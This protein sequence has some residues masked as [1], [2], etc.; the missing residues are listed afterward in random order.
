VR[1]QG[2][3]T[4]LA[5][6]YELDAELGRSGTGVVWRARD[7]IL[8]RIVVVKVL[9][10][11]L[12][13]DPAFDA[14]LAED[15]RAAAGVSAPG[16]T[17]LL[18]TAREDGISYLVREH[19]AGTSLRA[20]LEMGGPLD[21]HEAVR[22][23]L[24]VVE[25]LAA[26]HRARVLHLDLKPTNVV[27]DA[28][29]GAVRL[30]DLGIGSAV[31]ATRDPHEAMRILAPPT[32]APEQRAGDPVDA[33][34][35]V[36]LAGVLLFEA[37]AGE[38][39][40]GRRSVRD[41][42][43]DVPRELDAVVRRALAPDPDQRPASA[44][45]L[46]AALRP[47]AI[48][49]VPTDE[50]RRSWFRTWL[51]LPLLLVLLA[52]LA[53]ALGLW[54]G[55]LEIGGPL[56]IRTKPEADPTRTPTTTTDATIPVVTVS[57]F[58]PFGDLEEND[59]IAT[60]VIDGDASTAWRSENYFDATM[61]NKPG[62]GLLLDLGARHTI[63]GFRLETTHPGYTFGILVGDDPTALADEAEGATAPFTAEPVVE[64]S[65]DPSEGRYVLLWITSVVDTGDG[66]RAEVAEF[67]VVGT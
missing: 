66:N 43:P 21:T 3:T 42:E 28:A 31:W 5:E 67:A 8:D 33:R 13:D 17:H 32:A 47:F 35:D 60:A 52:G 34:T 9:R 24:G 16:L 56:G 61:N 11:E 25:A 62:V 30:T 51:A 15:S 14:R 46:A 29:S 45:D 58:D 63:T 44:T 27:V 20:I 64:G 12:A 55:R 57:T 59:E 1:T 39:P 50:P 36:F 10:P 38:P 41:L 26:A 48:G 22:I 49:A 4:V 19:A 7:R 6:R 2:P 23:A 40:G 54:L 18:D 37:L 53:I 65:L